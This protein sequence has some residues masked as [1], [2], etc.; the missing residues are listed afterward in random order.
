MQ[1]F[2]YSLK[3]LLTNLSKLKINKKINCDLILTKKIY[4]YI[5]IQLQI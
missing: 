5:P 2:D 3:F 4:R 1:I